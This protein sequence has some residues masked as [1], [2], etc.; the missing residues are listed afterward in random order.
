LLSLLP[1]HSAIGLSAEVGLYGAAYK[2]IDV[3]VAFPFI[4]AGLVLPVLTARWAS[5]AR[6]EFAAVLQRAFDAMVILALPLVVGAWFVGREL[7]VL[8]A[9]PDFADAGKILSLLIV[10]AAAIFIGTVF[11]HAVI[12]IDAQRRIIAAYAFTAV[13]ALVIYLVAIPRLG[14]TGAAYGTIYSELFMAIAAA[15][16]VRKRTG[17]TPSFHTTFRAL[18]ATAAMALCLWAAKRIGIESLLL[19]LPIGM[20]S[21]GSALYAFGGIDIDQ[22]KAILPAGDRQAIDQESSG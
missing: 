17:F 12:A 21:Y 14:Y 15:V 13:S 18:G 1:R 10:A 5:G 8:V 11:S 6:A 7:M 20:I 16:L 22:I 2:V 3:L 4:F 9:G 19:T